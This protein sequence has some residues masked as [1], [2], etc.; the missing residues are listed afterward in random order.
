[1]TAYQKE[2]DRKDGEELLVLV[3]DFLGR[4]EVEGP[5]PPLARLRELSEEEVIRLP[6]SAMEVIA[7]FRRHGM[8]LRCFRVR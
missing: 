7:E 1:V 5:V 2:Q 3:L 6:E 8:N 4:E